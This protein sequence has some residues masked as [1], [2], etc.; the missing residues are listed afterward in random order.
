VRGTI[1]S[2]L[3]NDETVT[4]LDETKVGSSRWL[5]V[6]VNDGRT[7]WAAARFITIG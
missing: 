7:G 3:H 4:I 1:V 6:K 5:Y 2:I